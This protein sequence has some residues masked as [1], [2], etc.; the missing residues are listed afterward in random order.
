MR[1]TVKFSFCVLMFQRISTI[2]WHP[3]D[4]LKNSRSNVSYWEIK[5]CHYT[6]HN[7][8]LA[9]ANKNNMIRK[10]ARSINLL[11]KLL[12]VCARVQEKDCIAEILKRKYVETSRTFFCV[13]G[14]FEESITGKTCLNKWEKLKQ[15]YA[16]CI[17]FLIALPEHMRIIRVVWILLKA[18]SYRITSK[19][20]LL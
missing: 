17:E 12:R 8:V 1:L 20:L 16:E 18:K 11:C 5:P 14:I 10:D 2:C 3:Q 9:N 4:L 13:S 7:G 19:I 15:I 6:R